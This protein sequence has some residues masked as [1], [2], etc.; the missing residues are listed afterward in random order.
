MKEIPLTRG[1]IALVDDE[2]YERLS[3]W[4]WSYNGTGYAVRSE[5]YYR[6]G[7]RRTRTILM[8]REIIK[9]PDGMETDHINGDRLDNRKCNIRPCDRKQNVWNNGSQLNKTSQ[10][11][12]VSYHKGYKKWLAQIG[13][14]GIHYFIG[15][16]KTELEAA[17][18]FDVKSLELYGEFAR[19]N[20]IKKEDVIFSLNNKTSKYVGVHWSNARHKWCA[21][22]QYNYKNKN[23]GRYDSETD[24]AL[25]YNKAANMYHGDKAKLNIID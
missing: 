4:K 16:Y 22:I 19:I 7:K 9:T 8:H 3:E 11:K 13:K 20:G 10:Y 6:D 25:A 1:K 21:S 12:G 15:W 14:N 17:Y 23:L 24:A 2:D 5:H 18:Y